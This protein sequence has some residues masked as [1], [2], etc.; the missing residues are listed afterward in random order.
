[1]STQTIGTSP[2]KRDEFLAAEINRFVREFQA[3]G[4]RVTPENAAESVFA[5]VHPPYMLRSVSLIDDGEKFEQ[6]K[7]RHRVRLKRVKEARETASEATRR[8]LDRQF[9]E[10]DGREKLTASGRAELAEIKKLL[11][12]AVDRGL[13]SISRGQDIPG[14][15]RFER[16][17]EE[18]RCRY[19]LLGLCTAGFE[20]LD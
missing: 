16:M 11:Q 17:A 9:Y 2:G 13:V 6:L 10:K 8:F 15:L 7:E 19:R 3:I 12:E 1:M 5:F 18:V 14:W 20:T 4:V